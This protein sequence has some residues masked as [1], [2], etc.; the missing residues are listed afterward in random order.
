MRPSPHVSAIGTVMRPA[1]LF[2]RFRMRNVRV[3]SV[4]IDQETSL[5]PQ[6]RRHFSGRPPVGDGRYHY[7][8]KMEMLYDHRGCRVLTIT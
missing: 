7:V 3:W 2:A 5:A 4:D 1:A 8:W 6:R